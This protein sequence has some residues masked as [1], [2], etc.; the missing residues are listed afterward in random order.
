MKKI[1]AFTTFLF[2]V[3]VQADQM[4]AM[5]SGCMGCHHAENK[6]IGPSFKQI[7]G[8]Y[9]AADVDK[10]VEVVKAGKSGDQLIWGGTLAMPASPAPADKVKKVIEWML[11]H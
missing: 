8:K 2:A 3:S 7:A 5:Q 9:S 10:L 11:T 6:L 4:T 1:L